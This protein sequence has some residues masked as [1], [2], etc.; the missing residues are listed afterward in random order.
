MKPAIS[1]DILINNYEGLSSLIVYLWHDITRNDKGCYRILMK[2]TYIIFNPYPCLTPKAI[3]DSIDHIIGHK[4]VM[5]KECHAVLFQHDS[6]LI[7][8]GTA[9]IF[10]KD[11]PELSRMCKVRRKQ[12]IEYRVASEG[13]SSEVITE[14]PQ[15]GN[16]LNKDNVREIVEE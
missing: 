10:R 12:P 15:C 7:F 5:C 4:H 8:K 11:Y 2:G 1:N 14:C 13:P 3:I 16:V 9:S 6:N